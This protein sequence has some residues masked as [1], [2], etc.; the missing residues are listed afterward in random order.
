MDAM[1]KRTCAACDG[2]LDDSPI[3][4]KIDVKWADWLGAT[5]PGTR[6]NV[7]FEGA[8]IFLPEERWPE[9]NRELR[10]HWSS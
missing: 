3:Q 2:E 7:R 8:R 1:T 6:R 5:I 4:V 9:L 10:A